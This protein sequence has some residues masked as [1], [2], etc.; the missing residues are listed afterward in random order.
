M[1]DLNERMNPRYEAYARAHG[2]TPEA[3]T[4]ADKAAWPGGS[5]TG[6]TLWIGKQLRQFAALHPDKMLDRT[7]NDQA[8][9][10]EFLN[11]VAA[12]QREAT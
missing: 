3:M 6:F 12:E 10:D 1:S 8:A 2:K 7:V 5:M 9:W 11:A 4:Q